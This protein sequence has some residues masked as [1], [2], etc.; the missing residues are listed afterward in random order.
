MVNQVGGVHYNEIGDYQHWD[1]V[2]DNRLNYLLGC[3]TKYVWRWHKKDGLK[4][5]KKS[6]SYIQKS[7]ERCQFPHGVPERHVNQMTL[8]ENYKVLFEAISPEA[9]EISRSIIEG[10]FP[11]AIMQINCLIE[12]IECAP[13]R[14]YVNPDL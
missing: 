14:T 8:N 11:S 5:L 1:W 12:T 7:I 6:I 10:K 4:D 3:A 2:V 13:S 9:Q